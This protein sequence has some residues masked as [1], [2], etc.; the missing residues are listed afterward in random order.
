MIRWTK[1]PMDSAG[2]DKHTNACTYGHGSRAV[3]LMTIQ[4]WS[5][6]VQ[7][8]V[9][10]CHDSRDGGDC[11]GDRPMSITGMRREGGG[12]N[13]PFL[14]TCSTYQD[15]KRG[16]IE[17]LMVWGRA[18]HHYIP[19]W[20][21]AI[22]CLVVIGSAASLAS[23]QDILVSGGMW[24]HERASGRYPGGNTKGA[25][26]GGRIYNRVGDGW[27]VNS[28]EIEALVRTQARHLV[29]PIGEKRLLMRPE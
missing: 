24:R 9:L 12:M 17:T 7:P 20:P 5:R 18:R 21:E 2:D 23:G 29:S 28:R 19:P 1:S 13:G 4:T 15:H 26:G 6:Q 10:M 25:H 11:S 8:G 27:G 22:K 16:W 3:A 14:R